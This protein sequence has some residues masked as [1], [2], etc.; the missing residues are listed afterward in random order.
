MNTLT[1]RSA[2]LSDLP[3]IETIERACFAENVRSSHR[4]LRRSFRSPTQSVWV[5]ER[6]DEDSCRVVGAMILRHYRRSLRIFS[7]AVL[8]EVQ[9]CGAGRQL[10]QQAIPIA[11]RSGFQSIILEAD[12]GNHALTQWYKKLGFEAE[13]LLRDYYAPEQH[14]VHMRLTLSPKEN[15]VHCGH[16]KSNCS[17]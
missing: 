16:S 6:H 3:I 9:H 15:E 2:V 17:K 4:A 7:L 12:N 8:P 14:G 1:I 10:V 11:Q 5:A 13:Y